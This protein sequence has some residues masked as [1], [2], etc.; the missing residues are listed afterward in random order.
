MMNAGA[1]KDAGSRKAGQ[2]ET[3]FELKEESLLHKSL[4]KQ[5][6]LKG[7]RK[8]ESCPVKQATT[9]GTRIQ[10]QSNCRLKALLYSV[11]VSC[12]CFYFYRAMWFI[13]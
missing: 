1:A 2:G 5:Q 4:S 13:F 6:G 3:V 11:P 12:I 7:P 10:R 9:A 8:A